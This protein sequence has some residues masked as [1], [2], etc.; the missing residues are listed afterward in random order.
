MVYKNFNHLKSLSKIN[1]FLNVLKKK[2]NFHVIN[3][4]VVQ[5][6]LKDDIFIKEIENGKK[7]IISFKGLNQKLGFRNST[8]HKILNLIRKEKKLQEVFF[9]VIVNKKIPIGSGLGGSS[10]NCTTIFNYLKKNYKLNFSKYKEVKILSKIGKDCP[11]FLNNKPKLI[12]NF[13]ERF[14]IINFKKKLNILIVYPKKILL[15]KEVYKKNIIF[16]KGL[17]ISKIIKNNN[18]NYKAF[19]NDLLNISINIEPKIANIINLLKR[20][21]S[22]KYCNIS[23]SG[24]ACFGIFGDKKS[25]YNAKNMFKRKYKNYWTASVKTIN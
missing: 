19:K 12:Y 22:C 20:I 24:S 10:S 15:T 13:G 17:G 8:I 21:D 4:F 5:T 1:I 18:L 7:D 11:I 9:K 16:S 23:G 2:K 25:L 14:K 6:D 3:S